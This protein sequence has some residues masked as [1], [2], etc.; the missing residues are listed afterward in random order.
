MHLRRWL[1]GL[2][3]LAGLGA[4][5]VVMRLDA[6]VRAY[7]AGPP[8]GGTRIY[9]APTPLAVG[10]AV[11]GGSLVRKLARLGYRPVAA[12]T[13]TLAPGEYRV[14]G[15]TVEYAERPSP[16]SWATAP[17]HVRIALDGGRV[18]GIDDVETGAVDR[19]ELEPE[20]LAAIGGGG[21]TLGTSAE[22][23]PP[24]CRSAVL[25]AED[26]NFFLHPG[27]ATSAPTRWRRGPAR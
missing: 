20:V 6:R 17:R 10:E 25:A 24:A 22:V 12:A 18:I 5:L 8:L 14:L 11:P 13:R 4:A 7:L 3:F 27:V 16:A 21:A 26:R 15:A 2:C 23:P 19:L 9:A 1:L